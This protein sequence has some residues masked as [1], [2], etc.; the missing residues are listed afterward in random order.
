GAARAARRRRRE[1]AAPRDRCRAR[2]LA[3]AQ[4]RPARRL[5][6]LQRRVPRTRPARHAVARARRGPAPRHVPPDHPL[7]GHGAPRAPGVRYGMT[8]E[9]SAGTHEPGA[10]AHEPGAGEHEPR[11]GTNERTGRGDPDTDDR[12]GEPTRLAYEFTAPLWVWDA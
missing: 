5:L 4:R 3:R 10:G 12:A 2:R 11:A 9:R 7:R 6:E 8:D 1:P